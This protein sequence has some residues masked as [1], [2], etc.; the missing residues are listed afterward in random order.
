MKTR[1]CRWGN[2]LAIRIPKTVAD[3]VKVTEESLVDVSVEDGTMVLRPMRSPEFD[4][5]ELL[6]GVTEANLHG[7]VDFGPCVG[8]EVW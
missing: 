3:E 6:A 2:S 7:E 4:L 8:A 1:V 5:D